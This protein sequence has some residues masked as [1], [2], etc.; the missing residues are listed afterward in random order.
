M[1]IKTLKIKV[2][3]SEQEISLLDYFEL[4]NTIYNT[5]A[6]MV[7]EGED[8]FWYV[9][10]AFEPKLPFFNYRNKAAAVLPTGFEAALK[11]YALSTTCNNVRLYNR[12]MYYS[13]ELV[14]F[15]SLDD[16]KRL[17]GIGS[18][19]IDQDVTFL[20]GLLVVIQQ[21]SSHQN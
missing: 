9:L 14:G 10:I 13:N 19:T 1:K 7:M 15:T 6:S 8:Y 2:E 3:Q 11:K 12:I 21:F 5:S 20:T 17:R 18:K 4:N 16:F